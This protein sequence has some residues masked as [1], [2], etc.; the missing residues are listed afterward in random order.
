MN[1]SG[2]SLSSTV[3]LA[4]DGGFVGTSED[5]LKENTE[6]LSTDI[7]ATFIKTTGVSKNIFLLRWLM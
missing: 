6:K 3:A 2:S 4:K 7:I 1:L 5:S